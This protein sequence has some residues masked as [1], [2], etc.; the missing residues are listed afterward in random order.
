MQNQ[1]S[2]LPDHGLCPRREETLDE[3]PAGSP[4]TVAPH[5]D[6]CEANPEGLTPE[7]PGSIVQIVDEILPGILSALGLP[8]PEID[9]FL[10]ELHPSLPA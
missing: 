3:A 6:S 10:Q 1:P 7:P 4:G 9:K 8:Q 2:S 5:L